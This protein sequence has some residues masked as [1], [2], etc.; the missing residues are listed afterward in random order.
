MEY[1]I[2]FK[3]KSQREVYEFFD[4]NYSKNFKSSH[5]L[6]T[7]EL[8]K[9]YNINDVAVIIET[10]SDK[11]ELKSFGNIDFVGN[12]KVVNKTIKGIKEKGF[13]LEDIIL[14]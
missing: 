2:S 4:R 7:N 1:C 6:I 10:I 8:L 11:K 12:E 14:K 3:G 5:K 13:S 9:I